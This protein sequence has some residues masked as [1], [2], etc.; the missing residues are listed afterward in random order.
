MA[1]EPPTKGFVRHGEI[2]EQFGQYLCT[3]AFL[4]EHINYE[5]IGKYA[6][7]S[8]ERKAY[9]SSRQYRELKNMAAVFIQ[10]LLTPYRELLAGQ[11]IS[12]CHELFRG[13]LADE[14]HFAPETLKSLFDRYEIFLLEAKD[15]G[16][17][18][19]EQ[20]AAI[21]AKYESIGK[22]ESNRP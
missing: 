6:A 10:M 12:K 8:D 17:R 5:I 20:R 11:S 22:L 15:A 2:P 3:L 21:R 14:Y 18:R 1:L 16:W 4:A 9:Q 19:A 7:N 13:F